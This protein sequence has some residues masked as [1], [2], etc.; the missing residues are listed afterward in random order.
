MIRLNIINKDEYSNYILEDSNNNKYEVNINFMG[1]EVPAIGSSI[2][3][4]EDVLNEKVSL[5]YGLMD[6]NID[7]DDNDLM[8]LLSDNK[9]IYLQRFYG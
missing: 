8:V 1:I 3:I 6:K 4:P 7:I 5:N 2:Y 9:K